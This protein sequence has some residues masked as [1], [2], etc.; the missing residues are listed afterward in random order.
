[1]R[2]D[3]LKKVIAMRHYL[4]SIIALLLFSS[5]CNSDE[6]KYDY[7]FSL[8]TDEYFECDLD[9]VIPMYTNGNLD[10]LYQLYDDLVAVYPNY[11]SKSLLGK[12]AWD[13]PIFR[14]DFAN[15][16]DKESLYKGI[17]RK[18]RI[19]IVTHTHGPEIQSG[20][21]AYVFFKLLCENTENDFLDYMKINLRFT[22]IP[23]VVPTGFIDASPKNRNRININRNFEYKHNI[24]DPSNLHYGGQLPLSEL[25]SQYIN[26]LLVG[27]NGKDIIFAIDKHNDDSYYA[28]N[29]VSW[30]GSLHSDVQGL[31]VKWADFITK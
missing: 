20:W 2:Y 9:Y 31:L 21:G 29:Y 12:D 1:M 18:N 8:T 19:L 10:N 22:V 11:V 24:V 25:E 28:R 6:D 13:N 17:F 27:N 23:I 26:N 16:V 5:S 14:Y 15:G 30:T 7:E 4:L 3:R